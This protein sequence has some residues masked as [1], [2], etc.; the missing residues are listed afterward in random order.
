MNVFTFQSFLMLNVFL[1]KGEGCFVGASYLSVS[2]CEGIQS[3]IGSCSLYST[4]KQCHIIHLSPR[5]L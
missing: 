3:R 2:V 5:E 1:S 4:M